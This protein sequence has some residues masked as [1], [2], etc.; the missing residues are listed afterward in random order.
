MISPGHVYD[1]TSNYDFSPPLSTRL[2]A[3]LTF[4]TDD[5]CSDRL[6]RAI[7]ENS[8]RW[9]SRWARAGGGEVHRQN[10]VTWTYTPKAEAG[11]E[12]HGA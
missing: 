5:P 11:A 12:I 9:I 10:G 7:V 8:R 6:L 4:F 1:F 3:P 2:G